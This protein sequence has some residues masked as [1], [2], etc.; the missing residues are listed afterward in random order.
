[1][2]EGIRPR[3]LPHPGHLDEEGA[4]LDARI[5][6]KLSSRTPL[7][8][9]EQRFLANLPAGREIPPGEILDAARRAGSAEPID[10]LTGKPHD[11]NAAVG[12][13]R[14]ALKPPHGGATD[15]S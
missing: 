8:E 2:S 10:A 1:M 14:S 5:R 6:L 4:S 13:S 9:A 3:R 7:D 11:I 12:G 15:A